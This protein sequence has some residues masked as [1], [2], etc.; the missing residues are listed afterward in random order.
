MH[1][2]WKLSRWTAWRIPHKRG[3]FP[4]IKCVRNKGY[5]SIPVITSLTE[6]C[7][8]D[9][10]RKKTHSEWKER[11]QCD[12]E[13]TRDKDPGKTMTHCTTKARLIRHRNHCPDHSANFLGCSGHF[14]RRI[15]P[16]G[17][18]EL[19]TTH[20][21]NQTNQVNKNSHLIWSF[22]CLITHYCFHR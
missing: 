7:V 4:L 10:K 20:L 15:A 22:C 1:T 11:S 17:T 14:G 13:L 12:T 21:I 2:D 6:R 18:S 19:Q 16:A 8:Q 9:I 3:L 5:L